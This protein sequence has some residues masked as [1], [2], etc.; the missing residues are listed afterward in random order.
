MT[1]VKLALASD[2][3]YLPHTMVAMLSV[4]ENATRPVAVHILGDG[5]SDDAKKIVEEGCRR[6]RAADLVFHD[7][8][9]IL[10]RERKLGYWARVI[11]ARLYIPDLID[12]RVLYLDGDTYTFADISPLF[13]MD[14]GGNLLGC[15]RDFGQI[16]YF[17]RET[18]NAR[19]ATKNCEKVMSPFPRHDYFN[20]GV[21]LFD[22]DAIRKNEAVLSHMTRVEEL[23]NYNMPDQDHLNIVFKNKALLLHPSWNAFYGLTRHAVR[24][25]KRVMPPEAVHGL[26]R[27][28]IIHYVSGPK[29]WKPF[30]IQWLKKTSV[31][32]K[33]FPRYLQYRFNERRLLAP[34]RAA[35]DHTACAASLPNGGAAFSSG[36]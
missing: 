17:E 14:M 30:D 35:M 23:K 33:R 36:D 13:E 27:P 21:L 16:I 20:S 26:R 15:V 19:L 5:L 1:D 11:L 12:G 28:K 9:D 29:I 34:Y 8:E 10:P 31:M 32:V 2:T 7:I 24:L 25:S 3:P 22:C 18:D 6:S 4:L